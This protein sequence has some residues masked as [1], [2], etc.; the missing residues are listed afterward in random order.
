MLNNVPLLCRLHDVSFYSCQTTLL[1]SHFIKKREVK[2][3]LLNIL[4]LFFFNFL[5]N[6]YFDL[7]SSLFF[8]LSSTP[9]AAPAFC[10]SCLSY[11]AFPII[12]LPLWCPL[13][14]WKK[15][16]SYFFWM[17]L[18]FPKTRQT[19]GIHCALHNTVGP[20]FMAA[21]YSFVDM[22]S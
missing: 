8:L 11:Y 10:F 9:S 13:T 21:E 4:H 15:I 14:K 19:S 22:S 7:H 1:L 12:L 17:L 16:G 3:K 6:Q 18:N 20:V 2:K 5:Q